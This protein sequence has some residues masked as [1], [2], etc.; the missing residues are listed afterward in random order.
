MSALWPVVQIAAKVGFEPLVTVQSL[1]QFAV[2]ASH[3]S[4]RDGPKRTFG[5]VP[6]CRSAACVKL[7]L[8]IERG[9]WGN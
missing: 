9:I 1:K 5:L 2:A 4:A 8:T 7:T 6:A 3:F